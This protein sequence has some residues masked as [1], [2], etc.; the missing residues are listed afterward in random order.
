MS[1]LVDCRHE[2]VAEACE[3]E[4]ES[5]QK[6]PGSHPCKLLCDINNGSSNRM[7][8]GSLSEAL[9]QCGVQTFWN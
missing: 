4:S 8:P 5:S 6:E 2:R 3:S 1:F 7:F 9:E